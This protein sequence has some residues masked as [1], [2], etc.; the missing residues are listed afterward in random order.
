[1]KKQ[2]Q[3]KQN[4]RFGHGTILTT[5]FMGKKEPYAENGAVSD[6][7]PCVKSKV[8]GSWIGVLKENSSFT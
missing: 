2:T 5:I 6:M 7:D 1:M 4:V 3:E 8:S